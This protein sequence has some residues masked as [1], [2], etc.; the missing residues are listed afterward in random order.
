MT[1]SSNLES[2]PF[3][4]LP[5]C[6]VSGL[7]SFALHHADDRGLAWEEIYQLMVLVSFLRGFVVLHGASLISQCSSNSFPEN[8]SIS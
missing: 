8:T 3:S 4:V 2:A 6:L 7:V 1:E 5:A